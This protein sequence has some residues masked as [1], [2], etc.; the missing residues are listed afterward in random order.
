MQ[1]INIPAPV[2]GSAGPNDAAAAAAGA[3]VHITSENKVVQEGALAPAAPA[4]AP[5]ANGAKRPDYVPEKFWDAKTGTVNTEAMSKSYSELETKLGGNKPAETPAPTE[6]KT[7]TPPPAANLTPIQQ[8]QQRGTADIQKDGKLSAETYAEALKQGFDKATV[9]AYISG[10]KAQETA[11]N[12]AAEKAAGGADTLSAMMKWAETGATAAEIAEFNKATL[13][14]NTETMTAA[15][16]KLAAKYTAAVG[17][18]PT[19]TVAGDNSPTSADI[20]SSRDSFLADMADPK[21][22]TSE[23]FRSKVIAKLDRTERAGKNVYSM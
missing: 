12:T 21:Y 20:Y 7:E 3:S 16:T 2:T 9:D 14:G 13:S 6:T 1:E 10:V 8:L 15:V 11:Y 18:E 23:D 4:P 17:R 22:K 19:R 5:A